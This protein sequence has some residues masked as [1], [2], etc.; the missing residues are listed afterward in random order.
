MSSS[1]S[2]PSPKFLDLF[3]ESLFVFIPETTEAKEK[4]LPVKHYAKLDE[5]LLEQMEEQGYG[6]YIS[7]NGFKNAGSRKEENLSLLQHLFCDIDAPHDDFHLSDKSLNTFKN[8]ALKRITELDKRIP[9]SI[10]VETR[11]GFH[12]YFRISPPENA[13]DQNT[14]DLYLSLLKI[15]RD[16]LGADHQSS[17]IPRV[18]RLPNSLYRKDLKQ[19]DT[20]LHSKIR[21]LT[22]RPD[23]GKALTEYA[24]L[25]NPFLKEEPEPTITVEDPVDIAPDL[26]LK[27]EAYLSELRLGAKSAFRKA[28]PPETKIDDSVKETFFKEALQHLDQVFPIME[29][30]SF[31]SVASPRGIPK[32]ERNS[33]LI[34]A[35]S[36][37]R[38]AG[39]SQ[40][41]ANQTLGDYNGLK[42]NEIKAVIKSAYQRA[43]P[44][45]FAW[46][47]PT[48]S[49]HVTIAEKEKVKSIISTYCT[50]R[51]I[52]YIDAKRKQLK[53]QKEQQAVASNPL[54]HEIRSQI[55]EDELNEA[56]ATIASSALVLS[57]A[58]QKNILDRFPSLFCAEYPSLRHVKL[59]RY[60]IYQPS[61]DK[62][63]K[64]I[65]NQDLEAMVIAF[66][67]V[68]GLQRLATVS[69]AKSQVLRLVA[70]EPIQIE[71][72]EIDSDKKLKEIHNSPG[73]FIPLINGVLDLKTKNLYPYDENAIFLSPIRTE[74]I[75]KEQV[76]EEDKQTIHK[77][78]S[79]I[80]LQN[81]E[82]MDRLAQIA[83]YTLLSDNRFQKSFF[84]LGEGANGKST[85]QNAITSMLGQAAVL[86]FSFNE[87]K[88]NFFAATTFGKRAGLVEEVSGNYFE[89][90]V[91]KRIT[92]QSM[93]TAD[94]KHKD[95]ISFVPCM[96]IIISV[97]QLPRVND[98][99]EGYYRRL[100]VVRFP[101]HFS[102]AENN[103]DPELEFKLDRARKA[104]L[105]FALDGL[106]S[107]I[108]EGGF[109]P[110]EDDTA[111]LDE[112]TIGN[113]SLLFFL[114]QTFV[115][116]QKDNALVYAASAIPFKEFYSEYSNFTRENGLGQ[117]SAVTLLDELRRSKFKP[118]DL[119][120]REDGPK[121]FV[122]G[123]KKVV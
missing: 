21:L 116:V 30:P 6:S 91:F 15:L 37:M 35:A 57:V 48:F 117:K 99:F 58:E 80:S 74:Y 104:F 96:K 118:F 51:I 92:G 46:N 67:E 17:D 16:E 88:N 59:G 82:R 55:S 40:E 26:I 42:P 105:H 79:D 19:S 110:T 23:A 102:L 81:Q 3:P 53:E 69:T 90:D 78:I 44:F 32:G 122:V 38:R 97:N 24:T 114:S 70:H 5:Q 43:L 50:N 63:Y 103:L 68:M 109:R 60:F 52:E 94:R 98:V 2:L 84:L 101:A 11:R 71:G 1:S 100:G 64:I 73:P 123:L 85:F 120:L 45:D 4:S 8:N 86:S 76:A 47:H 14:K 113:S 9:I 18:L 29:R 65:H 87:L 12:L 25:L 27:N 75:P 13:P 89:S 66:I 20:H 31:M 115:P 10:L 61:E 77:F 41:Q 83:G 7:V 28:L 106:E 33:T 34:I 95:P 72:Y 108:K 36:L 112:Y 49:P 39:C 107:L 93:I 62:P 22:C 119:T 54:P 121:V 111:L 56:A